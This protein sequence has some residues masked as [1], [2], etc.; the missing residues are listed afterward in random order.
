MHAKMMRHHQRI[1]KQLQN[2]IT[3]K[4]E[5]NQELD[6]QLKEIQVSVTE[7]QQIDEL[8]GK[9]ILIIILSTT[10]LILKQGLV[11]QKQE[12]RSVCTIY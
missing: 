5:E 12:L 2:S 9:L 10:L 4:K 11:K 3:E 6:K 8:A 7:R 1:L